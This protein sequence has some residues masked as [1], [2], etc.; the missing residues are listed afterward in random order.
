MSRTK[1]I[2]FETGDASEVFSAGSGQSVTTAQAN[3]SNG[4][5][6]LT[7]NGSGNNPNM[8]WVAGQSLTRVR[9]KFYFRLASVASTPFYIIVFEQSGGT[10]QCGVFLDFSGGTV[11]LN[12][13]DT[14]IATV[15]TSANL[16]G[17]FLAN[18]WYRFICDFTKGSSGSIDCSVIN[19]VTRATI[20]QLSTSPQNF[21]TGNTTA[22]STTGGGG[23]LTFWV[24]DFEMDDSVVPGEG[25]VIARQIRIGTPTYDN[26][27]KV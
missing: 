17:S 1:I 4:K 20:V 27:T 19:D 16:S 15:A 10:Q 18:T 22:F 6:S 11:T 9:L 25:Y 8:Y 21:N 3:G 14:T 12:V 5:Y 23:T 24:D 2:G 26:W 13:Y 7:D